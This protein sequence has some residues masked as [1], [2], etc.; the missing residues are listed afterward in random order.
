MPNAN[1][2]MLFAQGLRS[3]GFNAS[4]LT[5]DSLMNLMHVDFPDATP[6]ECAQALLA[7]SA[8]SHEA[9]M[10]ISVEGFR[11]A[12]IGMVVQATIDA[13]ANAEEDEDTTPANTQECEHCGNERDTDE[14]TFYSLESPDNDPT[15]CEP[16][17]Q[18]H[19]TWSSVQDAYIRT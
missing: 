5:A 1:Q 19:Y 2:M 10:R 11:F 7:A 9:F 8:I 6:D 3:N 4:G 14:V 17:I 15:I 16:C 12:A 18:R 13:Q